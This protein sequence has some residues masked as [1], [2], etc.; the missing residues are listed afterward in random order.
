M[1][2]QLELFPAPPPDER[3]RLNAAQAE[4]RRDRRLR[5]ATRVHARRG[6]H[7]FS[8]FDAARFASPELDE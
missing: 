5:E 7:R 1:G 2:K 6:R 4:M 3:E 8:S